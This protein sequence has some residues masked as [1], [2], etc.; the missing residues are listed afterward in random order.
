MHEPWQIDRHHRLSTCLREVVSGVTGEVPQEIYWDFGTNAITPVEWRVPTIGLGPGE[1][2]L[3]HMLDE[4]CSLE[5]IRQA[6]DIYYQLIKHWT[7]E[8]QDETNR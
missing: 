4:Q 6:E 7:P 2:K 1:Y 8:R 3:A 5:Q